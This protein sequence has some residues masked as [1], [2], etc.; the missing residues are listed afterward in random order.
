MDSDDY[1]VEMFFFP[2]LGG[3]HF[4]PMVDLARLFASHGVRTTVV[5]AP[6]HEAV[7]QKA[8]S[9]DQQAGLDVHIHTLEFPSGESDIPAAITS[10]DM[11][12]P[13]F[14]DTSALQQP[15][16]ELL[17]RR[18]PDCIVTD[19][20]HRWAAD[21]IDAVE[22]PRIIFNGN[23]CF[24]RC[25]EESIRRHSPHEKVRSDYEPFL[26]PG[27]P[28][29]IQTMRSQLSVYVRTRTEFPG[30][31][32]NAEKNCFGQVVNSFYDLE[33]SYVEYYRNEMGKKPWL[34]GPVSLCNRNIAD[35][36]ERGQKAA[37][38]EQT[39]LNWLD[40][41]TPRSVLYISFGSLVRLNST[42]LLELA[43]GLEA[44]DCSFIWAVGKILDSDNWVPDGFE[45]RVKASGRGLM[46][47]GWAPQ[48]L[49]L[50][51]VAVGGFLTHCGWNSA[52]EGI[53]AGVPMVTWPLSAEQF[54]NEKL[55]TDVL[56]VG[57]KVGSEEWALW[58]EERKTVVG[59]EKV[60]AAVRRLMG[61]GKEAEMMA[62]RAAELAEK[63][64]RAVEEGGSSYGDA[65]SLI[66]ELKHRRRTSHATSGTAPNRRFPVKFSCSM[67][68]RHASEH[69]SGPVRRLF[70]ASMT[71]AF[72]RNPSSYGMQPVSRLF[73]NRTSRNVDDAFPMLR[74][75]GPVNLL[76]ARVSGHIS[77]SEGLVI[78]KMGN[79]PNA[80]LILVRQMGQLAD[81]FG[82]RPIKLSNLA[83]QAAGE[84]VVQKQ[85]L[86]ER[87]RSFSDAPGNLAEDVE[88]QVE[89]TGR[90]RAGKRVETE[91]QEGELGGAEDFDGEFSVELVVA[92]V[93]FEQVAEIGEG[94]RDGAGELVGVGVEECDVRQ[95]VKEAVEGEVGAGEVESV[96]VDADVGADPGVG[97]AERVGSD[98]SFEVLDHRV[99]ELDALTFEGGQRRRAGW[100]RRRRAVCRR[101]RRRVASA[102]N[103]DFY[104]FSS[105][106]WVVGGMRNSCEE[107][108]EEE[109]DESE[110]RDGDG[111]HGGDGRND[112]ESGYGHGRIDL[113]LSVGQSVIQ[114]K[115]MSSQSDKLHIY[116]FPMFEY[117][118]TI[119]MRFKTSI[120]QPYPSH[121]LFHHLHFSCYSTQTEAKMSSQS[122]KLHIYFFPMFE[123][124]HMIPMVDMARL[125]AG[126]AVKATI[127][128]TPLN[129]DLF[130]K[131]ILRERELGLEISIRR[132]NFPFAEAGLPEGCEN[133]SSITSP[134]MSSKIHRATELLQ[135]PFEE[136][137]EE[138]R[139]DCLVADVFYPWAT[140]VAGKIGIPSLLFFGTSAY[141][142]CVTDVVHRRESY[143]NVESEPEALLVTDLPHTIKLT[144][145]QILNQIG[146]A[147]QNQVAQFIEKTRE[148][149][150][151]S[152]GVIINS[153]HELEPAYSEYYRMVMGRRAWHIGPVSLCNRDN[154][155]KLCRGNRSSIDEDKCLSWLAAKK[156][157]SVLYVCFGSLSRF[158]T[159]QLLELARGL[160]ASGQQF[161]W[162]VRKE[163][164]K[165][166]EKE[167][168][169]P[170]GF[171]SRLEGRGLIIRGWAPQVL[172]LEHEAVG[173]F[174][175]HCGW[176]SVLEGVTAGVPMITWPLSGEQFYNEKLVTEVIR[177][178]VRVGDPEWCT[179]PDD[180]KVDVKKEDIERA[181]EQILLAG[182]E[183]EEMR[184]RAKALGEAAKKAVEK[185]GS[186]YS[187]L[188]A[189]LEELKLNWH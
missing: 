12:A 19:T 61:G 180:S 97:D 11:S 44:S 20:F 151:R 179:W 186:S 87:P 128:L 54:Y 161:I 72:L 90:H 141:A 80:E 118:H 52:L 25:C 55:V 153:F 89:N 32:L 135:Q 143:Q 29:P 82:H 71:V 84:P 17:L 33:P 108:E 63:A 134:E 114:P 70:P 133:V 176:N 35:R 34:I 16:T 99:D 47:R 138:D 156:P 182:K 170:E 185:G 119:P 58:N 49:I 24:P 137:L 42:Q 165:E 48:L 124:G 41:K 175:T 56:K 173:G 5:I 121:S 37:I 148:A 7:L 164:T 21:A 51:H 117:G 46:I 120:P 53:C 65:E 169:L 59:R 14:I 92:E 171:E 127:V 177:V 91:V 152:Y 45:G 86:E 3:G 158:S 129:A 150:L 13:P 50:G 132:I 83:G 140:E 66:Q 126:H 15:L 107:E 10:A 73:K 68:S 95:L 62:R 136:L 157:S 100:W 163:G 31:A 94:S 22:I 75:M 131:T 18:R 145:R 1:T 6:S 39:I 106:A 139:P 188:K 74:G 60:E 26:L 88:V 77:E 57:V 172:I 159:A 168:W 105:W 167:E 78:V 115:Q 147:S 98:S 30:K 8:I 67:F 112:D 79:P 9:R 23:C 146:V 76:L 36:A 96:E 113:S 123:Y 122:D 81:R 130:S 102:A 93:E 43:N 27:L 144:K 103:D 178:G 183:A 184:S 154:E 155:D 28:D 125:F 174:M 101:R 109:D 189:L 111:G 149:E 38:D 40:S 85:H 187:N 142:L 4:I 166:E 64:K 181:V 116:L 2:Y 160:E 162:V 110:E 69:G 104:G